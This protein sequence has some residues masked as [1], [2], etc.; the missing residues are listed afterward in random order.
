MAKKPIVANIQATKMRIKPTKMIDSIA[1]IQ[2]RRPAVSNE[3]SPVFWASMV[4]AFLTMLALDELK[5]NS[6]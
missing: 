6:K 3:C 4:N 1:P 5:R 2:S